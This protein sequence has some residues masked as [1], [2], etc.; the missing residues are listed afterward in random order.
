MFYSELGHYLQNS[1]FNELFPMYAKQ[2]L[3]EYSRSGAL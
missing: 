2:Q 3:V 1:Y